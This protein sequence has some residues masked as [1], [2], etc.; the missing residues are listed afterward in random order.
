[1]GPYGA[2]SGYLCGGKALLVSRRYEVG[3]CSEN[4]VRRVLTELAAER[5]D[6]RSPVGGSGV[7]TSGSSRRGRAASAGQGSAA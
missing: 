6:I 2:T 7:A 1:M 4:G 3:A 5:R